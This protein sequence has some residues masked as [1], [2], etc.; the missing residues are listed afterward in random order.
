MRSDYRTLGLAFV[1][2]LVL[3]L[4]VYWLTGSG[5]IWWVF[6]AAAVVFT[7]LTLSG[8]LRTRS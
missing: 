1:G 6:I 7:V 4:L 2:L 8:A 5:V 3:T